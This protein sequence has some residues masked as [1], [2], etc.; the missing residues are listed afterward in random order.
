LAGLGP[1]IHVWTALWV[2]ERVEQKADGGCEC[3]HVSGLAVRFHDRGP[4]GFRERSLNTSAVSPCTVGWPGVS[5]SSVRPIA[6][7][8]Y[9]PFTLDNER[10]SRRPSVAGRLLRSSSW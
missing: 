8:C 1:A 7:F 9:C 4:D 5:R 6:I 10:I 3:G 2:Q